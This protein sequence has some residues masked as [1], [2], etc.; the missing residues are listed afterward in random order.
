MICKMCFKSKDTLV[1]IDVDGEQLDAKICKGCFYEIDK[2]RGW[3]EL[4]GVTLTRSLDSQNEVSS[5][6]PNPPK[7]KKTAARSSTD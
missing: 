2:I 1:P 7:D 5:T 6:P 4:R 3:F